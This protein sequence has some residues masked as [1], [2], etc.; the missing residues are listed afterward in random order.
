MLN[1]KKKKKCAEPPAVVTKAQHKIKA[2]CFQCRDVK[3][4]LT[5]GK[6]R[7]TGTYRMAP[8]GHIYLQN[9]VRHQKESQGLLSCSLD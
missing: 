4:S 9:T 8:C 3:K 6:S 1:Q 5:Q 2:S 7:L